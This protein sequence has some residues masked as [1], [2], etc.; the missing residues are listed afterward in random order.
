M[1]TIFSVSHLY[2][3][4]AAL[5]WLEYVCCLPTGLDY[6]QKQVSGEFLELTWRRAQDHLCHVELLVVSC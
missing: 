5:P 3:A 2:C 6:L 1:S 4:T